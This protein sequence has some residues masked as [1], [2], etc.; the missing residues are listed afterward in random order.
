MGLWPVISCPPFL[1]RGLE[2]MPSRC[3]LLGILVEAA[4]PAPPAP[5]AASSSSASGPPAPVPLE[6]PT[7]AES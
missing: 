4:P 5:S 3:F 7:E 1:A 2:L 6:H